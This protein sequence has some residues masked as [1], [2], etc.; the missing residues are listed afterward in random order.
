MFWLNTVGNTYAVIVLRR[1]RFGCLLPPMTRPF[2]E[3]TS[4]QHAGPDRGDAADAVEQVV[5][6]GRQHDERGQNW[7]DKTERR[8]DGMPLPIHPP[9]HEGTPHRPAD[10]QTRHCGI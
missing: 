1:L 8:E 10:V 5:V 6:G 9:D 2:A 3:R 7:I 4:N